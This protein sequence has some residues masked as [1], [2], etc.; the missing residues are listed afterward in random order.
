[1]GHLPP[2]QMDERYQQLTSLGD[3]LIEQNSDYLDANDRL[4]AR[5][6]TM[7]TDLSKLQSDDP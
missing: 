4:V 1:M 2:E 6:D 3:G 7:A 5:L